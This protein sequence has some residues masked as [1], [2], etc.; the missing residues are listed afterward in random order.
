MTDMFAGLK[1]F[2]DDV[3]AI[4]QGKEPA[5]SR[6]KSRQQRPHADDASAAKADDASTSAGGTPPTHTHDQHGGGGGGAG[7][8]SGPL[9]DGNKKRTVLILIVAFISIILSQ[10]FW[11]YRSSK[12]KEHE[13]TPAGIM[14]KEIE[15]MKAEKKLVEAETAKIVASAPTTSSV[16]RSYPAPAVVVQQHQV[17]SSCSAPGPGQTK[18]WEPLRLGKGVC[19][20][21][22]V[23][24][25]GGMY[26]WAVFDS[27]PTSMVGVSEVKAARDTGKL[28]P[29]GARDIEP[30]D[31]CSGDCLSFVSQHLGQPVFVRQS[32]DKRLKINL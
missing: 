19:V 5:E 30:T 4:E 21:L 29:N 11:E 6:R 16:P 3:R 20:E 10:L 1:R 28:L 31:A 15:K 7:G 26:F 27:V 8:G 23:P 32:L 22:D 25:Q 13:N 18:F 2:M 14:E 24:T 17:P 12:N 9:S